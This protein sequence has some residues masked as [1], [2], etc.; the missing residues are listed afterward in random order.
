MLNPFERGASL[1][2]KAAP[3]Q[4]L[5]HQIREIMGKRSMPG[6]SILTQR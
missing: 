5:M 2:D 6:E 4:D 1:L 3:I